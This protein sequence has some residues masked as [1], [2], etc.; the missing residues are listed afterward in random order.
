MFSTAYFGLLRVGEI[1]LSEHIIKAVD[2]HIGTNKKKMMFIL[3]SSKTHSKGVKPQ[4]IK[5]S[6]LE[7]HMSHMKSV[8]SKSKMP[9]VISQQQVDHL[10]FCSF[11]LLT[12]YISV[13]KSEMANDEPFFI[14][15]DRS[16]IKP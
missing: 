4:T 7:G 9:R 12:D 8:T 2:V 13:R 3:H 5:I 11:M 14:F 15:R 1:T 16:P 10:S 6:E